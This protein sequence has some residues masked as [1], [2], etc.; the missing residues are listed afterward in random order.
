MPAL[1][2]G[3]LNRRA[4]HERAVQFPAGQPV[5]QPW[6]GYAVPQR[7]GAAWQSPPLV[8]AVNP[9]WSTFREGDPP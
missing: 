8:P 7:L 1:H 6:R 2:G 5:A 3:L 9:L 4:I